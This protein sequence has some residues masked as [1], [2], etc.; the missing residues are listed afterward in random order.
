MNIEKKENF[1]LITDIIDWYLVQEKFIGYT[2]KQAKQCFK[3][4]YQKN[5]QKAMVWVWLR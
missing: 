5:W 3:K 2:I 1:I 4:K